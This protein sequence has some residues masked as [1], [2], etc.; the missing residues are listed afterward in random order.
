MSLPLIEVGKPFPD[1]PA[2]CPDGAEFIVWDTGP[3]LHLRFAK[4]SKRE[5]HVVESGP[6]EF[7]LF[8][9]GPAIFFLYR[10]GS[11]LEGDAP[12]SWH[13]EASERAPDP[14]IFTSAAQRD[15]LT[16]FLYDARDAIVHAI[17]YV[18]L[19]PEF[20]RALAQA[21]LTQSAAAWPGRDEYLQHLAGLYRR[22]PSRGDLFAEAAVR[23]KGGE[24]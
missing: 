7:G 15:M 5:I 16:V 13:L 9:D 18:S 1:C 12:Y 20:S 19:S 14:V 3:Q 4:P 11:L 8:V 10:F 17:G 2:P 6:C 21:M 24:K 23:C 22:Y